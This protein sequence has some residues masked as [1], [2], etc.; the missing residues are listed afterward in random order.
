MNKIQL[1]KTF[2]SLDQNHQI[3]ISIIDNIAWFNIINLDYKNCKTFLYLL[4]DVIIFISENNIEYIKQ[5]I[6]SVDLDYF[7]AS[8]IFQL[9]DTEYVV[10]THINDFVKEIINVLGIQQI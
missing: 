3:N 4:K 9:N 10:S 5:Y 2:I 7:K 6:Y 8:T 1:N